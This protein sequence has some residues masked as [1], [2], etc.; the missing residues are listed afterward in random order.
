LGS[1]GNKANAQKLVDK[2]KAAGYKAY[3]REGASADKTINRVLVGP[4]LKRQQAESK[5]A[6]LNKISGLK[7]IIIGYDPLRH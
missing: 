6:A 3:L 7:A 4:E 2:L 5:I 1:F